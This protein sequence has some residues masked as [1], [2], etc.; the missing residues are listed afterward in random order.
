VVVA[1]K[2]VV[3]DEVVVTDEIVSCDMGLV[4]EVVLLEIVLV[5]KK[6]D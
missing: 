5:A 2:M 4:V 3:T 6:A 1:D